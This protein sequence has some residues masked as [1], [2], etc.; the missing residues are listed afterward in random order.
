MRSFLDSFMEQFM[1][2]NDVVN[3]LVW[4]WPLLILI[5]GTGLYLTVKTNFLSFAKFGYTMK[6]TF[7][8]M[9][10]KEQVGE[11][12]VS[13]FEAVSTALAAAV[14]TGNIAGVGTAIAIGG[15]GAVFWMWLAALVGMA[16]KYAEVVLSIEYREKTEDGR[17][18]GGPMYYLDKGAN[19]KW[20]A[21]LFAVFGTTATFG[22][23][24]MVQSN[25][26]ADSLETTFNIEPWITGVVL[27]VAVGLVTLGG[28]KKIGKVTSYLVP[29]MAAV[30][31]VGGMAIII[32]NIE[33]VPAA[34]G[35]IFRNAFTGTA[36]VGGFVG[37][38]F[39][40][41]IRFG[42]ARGVF[43]NE[44]GLGSAPIAHAA[45]T[46]DHPVR[47]GLWGIFEVFAD[48]LV[49]CTITALVIVMT[50]AWDTGLD[51][52]ALTTVAFDEGMAFGGYIVTFG[53]VFFAFS[54]LLGWSYYGERCMEYLFGPKSII[55]YRLLFIPLIV[56]GAVG[57]LRAIWAL[58]DTLNGLM[59]I[60]NLIGLLILS[61]V[62]VRLTK[63]YF[64]KDGIYQKEK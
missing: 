25:S 10:S 17:Y 44:A 35:I 42:I 33:L 45:A 3:E 23:G 64:G 32:L 29:F 61:P 63:N 52:A 58:A 28:I 4:G 59:A 14:G 55:F 51:G 54:T 46:T 21:I 27:A 53:L 18:V 57:G 16:T 12:E 9:F 48:T 2:I 60:P 8:K 56:V 36:A 5:V 24:N 26:V 1:A 6:Q 50:G 39:T 20:L 37:S 40:M 7:F 47:Q 13:A 34:F 11:G 30:Y 41:A 15:P 31:I 43:T 19:K 22:I 38:T 62:V 49:L